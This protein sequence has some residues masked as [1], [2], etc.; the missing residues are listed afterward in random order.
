MSKVEITRLRDLKSGVR[1]SIWLDP[2]IVVIEEGHNP[3]NFNLPENRAHLDAL[4]A[5]IKVHGTLQPLLVRFESSTRQAVLVDGESRLRANLELIEEGVEI[6]SVPTIQVTATNEADRLILALTA[7]T[8]K[9]LSQWETGMSFLK[10]RNFG[11]S[12]EKIAERM[13]QTIAFIHRSIALSDAPE[14]MKELLS[15]KAVSPALA[16]QL[17]KN[18]GTQA[19]LVAKSKGATQ[20][21]PLKRKKEVSATEKAIGAIIKEA[22]AEIAACGDEKYEYVNISL[23]AINRLRKAGR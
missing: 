21:T 11:W 2:R 9:P 19:A 18:H 17:I 15:K 6:E 22:D 12:D 5:S 20:S 1:D 13:G 7:N 14:E 16:A 3:R 4:K 10:L 8:G 23:I